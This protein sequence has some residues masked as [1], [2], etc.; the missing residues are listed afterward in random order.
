MPSGVFPVP[1]RT[2]RPDRTAQSRST[3]GV[4]ARARIARKQLDRALA[5]GAD[6]GSNPELALRAGQLLAPAERS[7]IANALVEAL[8]DARRGEPFTLRVR[9]QRAEVRACA[10][11]LLALVQRLRDD[12]LVNVQGMALASLLVGD[13]KGPLFR[14]G[15]EDLRRAI[16]A[17]RNALDA[18]TWA[19]D[20]LGAAA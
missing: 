7:R 2:S 19:A 5:R 18:N 16:V 17:A 10:D 15:G 3:L 6:P 4:R 14:H 20:E 1:R 13:R 12:Q 8:G 11:E 9:P